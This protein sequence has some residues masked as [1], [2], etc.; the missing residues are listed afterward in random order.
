LQ[1]SQIQIKRS[2]TGLKKKIKKNTTRENKREKK[3]RCRCESDGKDYSR[4][5]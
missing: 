1:L 5:T 4:K 3:T 2:W